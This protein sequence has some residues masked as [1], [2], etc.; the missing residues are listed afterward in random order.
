MSAF[1]EK[2]AAGVSRNRSMLCVGLDV[3]PR[4]APPCLVGRDGWVERFCL[5]IAEATAD[6]VCAFKP[7]LAFFEALGEDGYRGLRRTLDG[8]PKE[9]LTICD[10][11]RGDI[12]HSAAAYA[13]AVFEVWGFDAVTVNPYLGWDTLA[14][15][16][17]YRDRGVIVLCKT[18]NSGSGDLQDLPVSWRGETM[19]L[20]E[21]VA[22]QVLEQDGDN[23][24]LVVGATYPREL[25]R[26]RMLAPS[27]PILLPGIGAQH[28]PL[29]VAVRAGLDAEGAGLIANVGRQV[30]YASRGADWQAAARVAATELRDRLQAAGGERTDAT[31][32]PAAG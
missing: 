24:G 12:G 13:R 5:G 17:E 22:H 27:L 6:L 25:G 16:A 11:K 32:R 28:G 7:N 1:T 15:F 18:S 20:Y 4:L 21:V 10:A 30:L 9:T 19:P 23:W 3:D 26:L 29:E 8:L 14:P 2:L 31:S